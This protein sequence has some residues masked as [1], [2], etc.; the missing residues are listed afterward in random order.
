MLMPFPAVLAAS[1]V[2][3]GAP[4]PGDLIWSSGERLEKGANRTFVVTG[5]RKGQKYLFR[6]RGECRWLPLKVRTKHGFIDRER[7]E[8]I[9]GIDFRATLGSSDKQFL[10]VGERVPEQTEFTFVADRDD[11]PVHLEDA[12]QLPEHVICAIDGLEVVVAPRAAGD[13]PP[14]P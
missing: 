2:L 14:A 5:T 11:V 9:F 3:A 8:R 7:T 10:N 12:F 6:A 1:L 4:R 13:R